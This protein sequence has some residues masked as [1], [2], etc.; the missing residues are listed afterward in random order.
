MNEDEHCCIHCL[1]IDN[2]EYYVV[3]LQLIDHIIFGMII[4][5]FLVWT[6]KSQKVRK[7]AHFWHFSFFWWMYENWDWWRDNELVSVIARELRLVDDDE[8]LK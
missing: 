4:I 8:F 7:K 3:H 5:T 6:W 2:E 1:K